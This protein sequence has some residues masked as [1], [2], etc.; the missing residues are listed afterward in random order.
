MSRGLELSIF[1]RQTTQSP[2]LIDYLFW[3]ACMCLLACLFL[4]SPYSCS[5]IGD[6]TF[7]RSTYCNYF[8]RTKPLCCN[9]IGNFGLYGTSA[10]SSAGRRHLP[11]PNTNVR[12][13]RQPSPCSSSYD[14]QSLARRF[15]HPRT[16]STRPSEVKCE[17]AM[18]QLLVA[19]ATLD[20]TPPPY[21]PILLPIVDLTCFQ[22]INQTQSRSVS[23]L[24]LRPLVPA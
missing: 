23:A 8:W 1:L 19:Q 11:L 17:L 6:V 7:N 12:T 10:E 21:A 20:N 3:P 22:S 15:L 16:H 18:A 9:C 14:D 24:R 4:A 5:N 13:P 2:S